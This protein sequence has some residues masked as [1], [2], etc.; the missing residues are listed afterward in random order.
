MSADGGTH[1]P[2]LQFMQELLLQ[3]LQVRDPS[4]LSTNPQAQQQQV[5]DLL[6]SASLLE[7]Q[8]V[9]R[10]L[11]SQLKGLRVS[12]ATYVTAPIGCCI[13]EPTGSR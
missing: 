1:T 13:A 7:F 11:N 10:W 4:G 8:D 3:E 2:L 6:Y 9:Y 5:M 12:L